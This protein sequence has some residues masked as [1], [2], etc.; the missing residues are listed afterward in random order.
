[1]TVAAPLGN[2]RQELNDHR[3]DMVVQLREG[4][5]LPCRAAKNAFHRP[6]TKTRVLLVVRMRGRMTERHSKE[7]CL[8]L[9]PPV[10]DVPKVEYDI[11]FVKQE[12]NSNI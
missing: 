8:K 9:K 6:Y 1:M 3:S 12:A 10:P 2:T 7:T 5:V 4:Y 11:D